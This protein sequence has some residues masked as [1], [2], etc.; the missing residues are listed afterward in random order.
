MIYLDNNATTPISPE[1]VGAMAPYWTIQFFNPSSPAGERFG[2]DRPIRMA[3]IKLAELLGGECSNYCL[4]SGATEANNWAID[5]AIN[6]ALEAK[7]CCKLLVS[8]IEHVAI[9]QA[10]QHR[11]AKDARISLET[12]RVT[13]DGLVD[14]DDLSKKMT[15]D[16]DFVSIMLANN[17]S[18]V[19]QPVKEIAGLVKKTSPSCLLHTDATQAVGKIKIDLDDDLSQVDLLSLSAH[20]FGGPKGIGALFIRDVKSAPPFI[21]G[22]NQQNG[23]RGGTENPPLAAGMAKAVELI[24]SQKDIQRRADLT[25]S[26]RDR[27]ENGLEKIYPEVKVLGYQAP[28]LANTSLLLF[29]GFEGEML[30][31]R[32]LEDGIVVSTGAACSN[33]SDSPSHVVLGM[34]IDYTIARDALRVSLSNF[35]TYE[36]ITYVLNSLEKLLTNP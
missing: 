30:V 5:L 29:A 24:G 9:L 26:M 32:L 35:T 17:E 14:I 11:A 25:H 3:P 12:I 2:S 1:V 15:P 18:G 34:G 33:G 20:K 10:A 8:E 31:H 28:R 13:P 27:L 7:D 6:K 4:T 16:T 23:L 36:D 22:G 21:V 19:I